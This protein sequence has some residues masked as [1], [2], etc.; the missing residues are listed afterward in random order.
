MAN[1]RE[2]K[3]RKDSVS[4]TKQITRT[5]E[6]VSSAKISRALAR[7][8]KSE[9][10]R[11]AIT[12]V[13]LTVAGDVESHEDSPLLE[14]PETYDRALIIAVSSDRGLA[15]GFNTQ[16]ARAVEK[17][18]E[19]FR[20][21]GASEVEL[22]TCGRKVSEY[23]RNYPNVV[24]QVEGESDEPSLERAQVIANYVL[25]SFATGKLGRID[26]I[27]FHAKNRVEQ[28]LR[29]ERILPLDPKAIESPHG[30]RTD[31]RGPKR[32]SSP[33][34]YVPSA[35]HVLQKLIPS[36][37]LTV[38]HQAL[39]DSAAAEHGARRKAMHSATENA[40]EIIES[41]NRTYNRV[42]Q[43]SITTEIN[44]IVGGA[45]ALEEY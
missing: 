44:E 6:M 30:P 18:V 23:F 2:I 24:M 32:L 21:H 28:V 16:I 43:A 34:E 38:V 36:Y 31:K 7:A 40:T 37:V 39:I 19:H 25:D 42:R 8:Q 29:M 22:I 10:Y 9:P 27:H 45:A 26:V 41:L 5:M 35:D 3:K 14:N 17:H 33:F 11:A 4:T 15:G 20:R 1:L 12:D 13:M